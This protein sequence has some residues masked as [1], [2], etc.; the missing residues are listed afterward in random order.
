MRALILIVALAGSAHAL[1]PVVVTIDSVSSTD[2]VSGISISSGAPTDIIVSTGPLYRQACVQNF[3]T[4]TFLMCGENVNVST[5]TSSNLVGVQIAPAQSTSATAAP[6]CFGI[7]AGKRWYCL[8]SG[9]TGGNTR[10]SI[11]RG[12]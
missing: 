7:P 1:E 11:T 10:A 12:R 5:N 8:N 3:D 9:T 4:T 6:T 2:T